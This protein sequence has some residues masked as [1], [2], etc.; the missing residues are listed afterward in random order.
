MGS[1]QRTDTGA[2]KDDAVPFMFFQV[3]LP[4]PEALWGIPTW[5]EPLL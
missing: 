1:L 4:W 3:P 5:L 2:R